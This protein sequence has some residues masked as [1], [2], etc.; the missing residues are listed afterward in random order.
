MRTICSLFEEVFP[1]LQWLCRGLRRGVD[2]IFYK[3]ASLVYHLRTSKLV[4]FSYYI[5]METLRRDWHVPRGTVYV[6]TIKYKPEL[7]CI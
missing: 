5:G 7:E 3:F 6:D 2:L 1:G 4:N